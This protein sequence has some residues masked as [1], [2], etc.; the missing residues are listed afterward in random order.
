[1]CE[2]SWDIRKVPHRSPLPCVR[3]AGPSV[4]PT[5]LPRG[6]KALQGGQVTMCACVSLVLC[7]HVCPLCVTCW[8]VDSDWAVLTGGR[9]V[10]RPLAAEGRCFL[11][12]FA[13]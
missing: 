3:Q 4:R 8:Q 6:R 12:V 11:L 13:P 10:T 5:R 1:M 7:A 2:V 9:F